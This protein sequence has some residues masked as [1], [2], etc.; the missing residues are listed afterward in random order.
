M[1]WDTRT[2]WSTPQSASL[3]VNFLRKTDSVLSN[4]KRM[5]IDQQHRIVPCDNFI[6]SAIPRKENQWL[7]NKIEVC[8][9]FCKRH[10]YISSQ[11]MGLFFY[12]HLH[13]FNSAFFWLIYVIH[14]RTNI[15]HCIMIFGS[16]ISL[17]YIIKFRFKPFVLIE[18]EVIGNYQALHY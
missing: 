16:I 1:H 4:Q 8:Y 5:I 18:C 17:N 11:C 6:E 15:H 2:Q 3:G 7:T 13:P 14:L 9:T 12:L 10:H